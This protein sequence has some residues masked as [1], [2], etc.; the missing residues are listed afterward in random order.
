[1]ELGTSAMGFRGKTLKRW[2]FERRTLGETFMAKRNSPEAAAKMKISKTDY[3]CP[4]I[5]RVIKSKTETYE[6]CRRQRVGKNG[7]KLLSWI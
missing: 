6:N 1:M 5:F 3:V 7:S 2:L 4:Y